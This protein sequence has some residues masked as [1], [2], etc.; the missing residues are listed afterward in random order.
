MEKIIDGKQVAKEIIKD[1]QMERKL[2]KIT[3]RIDIFLIGEDYASIKYVQMKEK[4]AKELNISCKINKYTKNVTE[5]KLIED[6]KEKNN[7]DNIHGIIVQ[8]PI[9]KNLNKEKILNTIEPKKDIDGLTSTNLGNLFTKKEPFF[10][11]AT[12]L[13]ILKMFEKYKIELEGK[14]IVII[15]KSLIVGI[16]LLGELLKKNASVTILSKKTKNIEKITSKADILITAVGKTKIIKSKHIK[17]NSIVIDVGI[18]KD[19][20]TKKISGDVDYENVRKKV[21]YITPVPGG[22]GATTVPSLIFNLL[23]SIKNEKTDK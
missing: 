20:K 12:P 1:I 17:K 21:K 15:G 6:I 23:Q 14:N 8:L 16:P 5:K 7:D 4:L 3:P 9:P 13:G 2:I 11:P 18:S 10:I 19:P 22:V